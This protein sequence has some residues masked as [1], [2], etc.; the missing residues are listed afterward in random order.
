MNSILSFIIGIT[1]GQLALLGWMAL[2]Y[3]KDRGT[4]WNREIEVGK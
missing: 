4:R 3:R 2:S 1:V